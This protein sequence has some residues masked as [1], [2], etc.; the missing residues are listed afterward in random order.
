MYQSEQ[1]SHPKRGGKRPN[2]GRKPKYG[3]PTTVFQM[4]VPETK[5]QDIKKA[6][7]ILLNED[8]LDRFLHEFDHYETD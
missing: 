8:W 6:V 4:R 3:E 2:S 7:R 5:V 1:P